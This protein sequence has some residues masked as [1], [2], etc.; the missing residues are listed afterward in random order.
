[1]APDIGFPPVFSGTFLVFLLLANVAGIILA[2]VA[3]LYL[4]RYLKWLSHRP[5]SQR[6]QRPLSISLMV[7]GIAFFA[8]SV[9]MIFMKIPYPVWCIIPVVCISICI[10]LTHLR[11]WVYRTNPNRY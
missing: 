6:N 9:V 2:I 5:W 3:L 10:F 1:M 8:V 7:V 4:N 11:L